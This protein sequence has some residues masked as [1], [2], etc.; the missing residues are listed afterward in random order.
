METPKQRPKTR[1][2]KAAT[3]VLPKALCYTLSKHNIVGVDNKKGAS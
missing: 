2:Q 3:L 1:L